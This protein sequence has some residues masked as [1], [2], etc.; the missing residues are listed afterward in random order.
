MMLAIL[1]AV[2]VHCVCGDQMIVC[3]S[4]LLSDDEDFYSNSGDG[5]SDGNYGLC[6]MET[7]PIFS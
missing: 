4:K 1:L 6:H 7:I 2:V 5:E 3:V